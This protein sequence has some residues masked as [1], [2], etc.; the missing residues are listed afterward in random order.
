ME[1]MTKRPKIAVFV[2]NDKKLS[3]QPKISDEYAYKT[4]IK[5]IFLSLMIKN[6][7]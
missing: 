6:Y 7:H 2:I 5:R 4:M 3:F 1:S